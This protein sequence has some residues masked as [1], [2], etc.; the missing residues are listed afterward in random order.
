MRS[1]V[2]DKEGFRAQIQ[3]ATEQAQQ[4]AATHAAQAAEQQR[5]AAQAA[6]TAAAAQ[7]LIGQIERLA[8]L[9][10]RGILSGD[11]FEAQKARILAST[12]TPGG[13][14]RTS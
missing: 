4:A 13:E 14:P 9:R 7:D 6:A 11:E 8:S 2:S 10:D 5:A 12:T 3:R 1:A